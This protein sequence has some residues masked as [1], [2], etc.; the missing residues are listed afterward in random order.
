METRREPF[1]GDSSPPPG[2]SHSNSG[3]LDR[4]MGRSGA[5]L[6]GPSLADDPH[7]IATTYIVLP[8]LNERPNL[9]PLVHSIQRTM[10]G[11][12]LRILIVDDGSTDGTRELV[13]QL[14]GQGFPI[15]VLERGSKRGIGSAIRDGLSW[16]LAQG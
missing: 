9:E 12:R 5:G 13:E 6:S 16:C 7:E 14:Q 8:T 3:A 4:R 15:S 10:Q 11:E 2:L 1:I